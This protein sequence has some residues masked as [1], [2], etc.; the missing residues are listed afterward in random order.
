[1]LWSQIPCNFQNNFLHERK[2]WCKWSR[3]EIKTKG[4]RLHSDFSSLATHLIT[5]S[6]CGGVIIP[7]DMLQTK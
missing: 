4:R 6:N 3:Q 1:M 7:L 5:M 2:E